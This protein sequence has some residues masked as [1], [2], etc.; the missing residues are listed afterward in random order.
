MWDKGGLTGNAGKIGAPPDQVVFGCGDAENGEDVAVEIELLFPQY[1]TP[2]FVEF[3]VCGRMGRF[4]KKFVI[5][6]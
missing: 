2:T 6:N 4:V 1:Q 5:K 3:F